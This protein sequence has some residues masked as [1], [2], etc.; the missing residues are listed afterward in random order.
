MPA[1]LAV[2]APAPPDIAARAASAT[3]SCIARTGLA[4]LTVDDVARE[5][6][7]SRATLYRAFPSK[8]AL[9]AAAAGHEAARVFGLI[10]EATADA[11]SLDDVVTAVITV[12]ARALRASAALAFVATH[13]P[14]RLAPHLEFAGGDA[15]LGRLARGLAPVFRG[16]VADPERAAEW[17][18]RVGLCALLSPAPL[19]DP[20]DDA[21]VRRFVA[22]Y[23]TPGLSTPDVATPDP[24]EG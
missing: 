13:E 12:G 20:I 14:H 2:A 21:A 9:V 10:A 19:V 16:W 15:L 22:T 23:V 24:E 4:R 1:A 17:V 6:G 8:Q 3:L 18:A 11:S 7:V 5:A